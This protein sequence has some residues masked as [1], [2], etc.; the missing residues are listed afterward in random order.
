MTEKFRVYDFEDTSDHDG[1]RQNRKKLTAS[2]YVWRDPAEIPQRSWIYGRHY[3]RKFTSATVAPGGLAKTSLVLVEAIA[4]ALK[5][6]LLSLL[7]IEQTQVWIW[8]GED[9]AEEIERRIA[10]I[11][12]YYEIDARTLEGRLFLNS[13]RVDPIKLAAVT[14][15]SIA[16]DNSL[17]DDLIATI[18]E[19][20]IGLAIFDPFISTHTVPE[21]DNTNIDAVVKRFGHIADETGAAVELVHHVRK[22]GNGQSDTTVDDARG[23]SALINAVRSARVLNR[24]SSGQAEELKIKEPR[25][26]FRA[27]TGK[28]NLAPP[29]VAT[30]HQITSV[31][32]PNRDAVAVVTAW[33]Y[34][35]PLDRITPDH[36]R[37][38]RQMAAE[39]NFRKDAR[40]DDWIGRAVAEVV[41]LDHEEKADRVIIK[42]ALAAWF[43]NG[44]L[45]LKARK[46]EHRKERTYVMPGDWNEE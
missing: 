39:G 24:M 29:E 22:A 44:V 42:A 5:R 9:P 32:L 4:I 31:D 21:S 23:A 14:R 3:I 38:V 13:G 33:K 2:P 46:D 36:M 37:R 45:A 6:P 1:N 34:P 40:S 41:D 26:Y 28:A 27:D 35:S 12:Q 17:Q 11:C 18:T 20:E 16:L 43:A 8:N 15:G 30:W 7:P 19:N 25:L 10:A